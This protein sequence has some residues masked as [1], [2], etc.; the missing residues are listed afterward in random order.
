MAMADPKLPGV[1]HTGFFRIDQA[2]RGFLDPKVVRIKDPTA[3][4]MPQRSGTGAGAQLRPTYLEDIEAAYQVDSY[5]RQGVDKYAEAMI[6]NGW[7]LDGDNDTAIQYL[8]LR[9]RAFEI[10]HPKQT[11]F[12]QLIA[13]LCRDF[14]K[15][16]NCF[17]VKARTKNPTPV[18]GIRMQGVGGQNPLGALFRVHPLM[19]QEERDKQ[20]RHIGWIN[21]SGSGGGATTRGQ[22]NEARFKLDEVI[23]IPYCPPAGAIWGESVLAPVLEDVRNYR[24]MEDMV[25]KLMYKHLHPLM[26][27]E[28]PD[29]TGTGLGRQEDVDAAAAAHSLMAPDG[30]IVTGPGTKITMLGAESHALRAEGYMRMMRQR[31][32]GG[33]GMSELLMGEATT[34]SAGSAEAL[35]AFMNDR[36]TAYQLY[37]SFYLTTLLL[38]ELLLE[39][40][41]DPINQ[42]A[43][44]VVWRW[45]EVDEAKRRANENHALVLF[46]GN[47]LDEGEA[48]K[49]MRLRPMAPDQES[50]RYLNRVQIPLAEVTASSRLA[51]TSG[52]AANRNQPANQHGSRPAATRNAEDP[53]FRARTALLRLGEAQL[54]ESLSSEAIREILAV[55]L[56]PLGAA[57]RQTLHLLED[58]L[59]LLAEILEGSEDLSTFEQELAALLASRLPLS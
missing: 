25:L 1:P 22:K 20:G 51:N 41:F 50:L 19:M 39:G 17:L 10:A 3:P 42:D 4:G 6:L 12:D 23:H 11:P 48:R 29:T 33:L 9:F 57:G 34:A 16:G 14:V 54:G 21:R 59:P 8:K 27:Q 47:L 26:H 28:V 18:Q 7:Y 38:T 43:D 53:A 15:Y 37:F 2:S 13:D 44:R 30:F 49:R 35:R 40:G 46:Q 5:V 52:T 58:A 36:S 45:N 31:V 56:E 24:Q 32:Y 55:E